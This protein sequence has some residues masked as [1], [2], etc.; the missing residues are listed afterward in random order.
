M[1]HNEWF[2]YCWILKLW[3]V[4]SLSVVSLKFPSSTEIPWFY[5]WQ[6][7]KK[8]TSQILCLKFWRGAFW[9][10]L[11]WYI[12]SY[13]CLF[14]LSITFTKMIL[15]NFYRGQGSP[16]RGCKELSMTWWLNNNK[17]LVAY[18]DS[19][20]FFPLRCTTT[21][22]TTTTKKKRTIRNKNSYI[23]FIQIH[24]KLTFYTVLWSKLKHY[25]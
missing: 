16:A 9:D 23:S 21:T 15:R 12:K 14:P 17:N 3:L 25:F 20:F 18:L 5:V 6:K 22:T 4:S 19:F 10:T 1:K 2:P 11:T 24:P 7:E 8:T 13:F